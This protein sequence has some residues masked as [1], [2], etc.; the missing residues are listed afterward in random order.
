MAD[1]KRIP[2]SPSQTSVTCPRLELSST[3]QSMDAESHQ[4]IPHKNPQCPS[5]N[6]FACN[7]APGKSSRLFAPISTRGVLEGTGSL[8]AAVT[9]PGPGRARLNSFKELAPQAELPI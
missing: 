8:A 2:M 7:D 6:V 3:A 5:A 1:Q 9:G 4:K